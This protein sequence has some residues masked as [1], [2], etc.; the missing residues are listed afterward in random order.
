MPS[1]RRFFE[2]N[3]AGLAFPLARSRAATGRAKPQSSS[4]VEQPK[5]DYGNDWPLYLT[6]KMNEAR[7][8]RPAA[9]F[10][11]VRPRKGA[12]RSLLARGDLNPARIHCQGKVE[13]SGFEQSRKF[14]WGANGRSP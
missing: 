12:G 2:M 9:I 14:L 4:A 13:S 6:A 7:R 11:P 3:L 8:Q 1:R 5:R 10:R